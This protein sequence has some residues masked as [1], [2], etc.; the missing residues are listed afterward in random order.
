MGKF[1]PRCA[2][3]NPHPE[4]EGSDLPAGRGLASDTQSAA[5]IWSV[6]I[7]RASSCGAF[8]ST[9]SGAPADQSRRL[10]P[11][12]GRM[13]GARFSAMT[14]GFTGGVDPLHTGSLSSA[15]VGLIARNILARDDRQHGYR[16]KRGSI[17]DSSHDEPAAAIARDHAHAGG[18]RTIPPVRP[19][20]RSPRSFMMAHALR[21]PRRRSAEG[22]GGV[23][24][25][26]NGPA[27]FS[28]NGLRYDHDHE[29]EAETV[30][31]LSLGLCRRP[32]G[33]STRSAEGVVAQQPAID[34]STLL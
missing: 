7:R 8:G 2:R 27:R 26:P 11:P 29:P 19:C 28:T 21:Q 22:R 3:R 31:L 10:A 16:P 4:P 12:S 15:R 18:C 9:R 32:A 30:Q 24:V 25:V 33:M 14:P 13:R 34:K 5:G 6:S 17:F 23:R 1:S 20:R